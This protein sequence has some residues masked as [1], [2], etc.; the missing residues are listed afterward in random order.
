MNHTNRRKE[1]TAWHQQL[2]CQCSIDDPDNWPIESDRLHTIACS[3]IL[4]ALTTN[5]LEIP[6]EAAFVCREG[7]R[8]LLLLGRDDEQVFAVFELNFAARDRC[9][10]RS[11]SAQETHAVFFDAEEYLH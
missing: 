2:Q 7:H 11:L 10:A 6:G 9:T 8:F 3:I 4:E 5:D 1:S